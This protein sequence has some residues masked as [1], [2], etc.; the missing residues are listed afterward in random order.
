MT[1]TAFPFSSRCDTVIHWATTNITIEL[2]HLLGTPGFCL[3]RPALLYTIRSIGTRHSQRHRAFRSVIHLLFFYPPFVSFQPSRLTQ[4]LEYF[5]FELRLSRK[6][7]HLSELSIIRAIC[8]HGYLNEIST[9]SDL[10]GTGLH[11]HHGEKFHLYLV[12][13]EVISLQ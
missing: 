1:G 5:D 6:L 4:I 8:I 12:R 11:W 3:G 9:R 2:K 7:R 10:W 13:Y